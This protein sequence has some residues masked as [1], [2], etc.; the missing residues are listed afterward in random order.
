MVQLTSIIFKV[1][2]SMFDIGRGA[3]DLSK[4]YRT[5]YVYLTKIYLRNN[6]S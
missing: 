6:L 3:A 5:T 2:S 1:D 4:C